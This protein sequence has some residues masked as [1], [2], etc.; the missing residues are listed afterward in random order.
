MGDMTGP[1][2]AS[3]S[4]GT[5]RS[6]WLPGA[7]NVAS[8]FEAA[9]WS[10][11][12]ASKGSGALWMES[13]ELLDMDGNVLP[14]CCGITFWNSRKVSLH[15]HHFHETKFVQNGVPFL[16]EMRAEGTDNDKGAPSIIDGPFTLKAVHKFCHQILG[17]TP[18]GISIKWGWYL[19]LF[20]DRSTCR[21]SP[22]AETRL[23][24]IRKT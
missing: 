16:T 17:R 13:C 4:L 6:Q 10:S 20:F 18:W 1:S 21:E 9:N 23:Y 22:R 3:L 5:Q 24:T 19:D 15:T 14:I 7:V 12:V 2:P 11:I 8:E